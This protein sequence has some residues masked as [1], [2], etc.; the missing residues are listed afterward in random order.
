M[1]KGSPTRQRGDA[2]KKK[3]EKQ[4]Q[5][6]ILKESS[7]LAESDVKKRMQLVRALEGS[8]KSFFTKVSVEMSEIDR[9]DDVLELTQRGYLMLGNGLEAFALED[10]KAPNGQ[11]ELAQCSSQSSSSASSGSSSDE[12][13]SSCSLSRSGSSEGT[14]SSSDEEDHSDFHG[15]N[16]STSCR[17]SS[18]SGSESDSSTSSRGSNQLPPKKR[19]NAARRPC[20]QLKKARKEMSRSPSLHT[21]SEEEEESDNDGGKERQKD[22]KRKKQRKR[23]Q[24]LTPPSLQ[25]QGSSSPET[26]GPNKRKKAKDFFLARHKRLDFEDD[27]CEDDGGDNGP[28]SQAVA[29][30]S[31]AEEVDHVSDSCPEDDE[32]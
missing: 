7:S 22:E 5:L 9:N 8:I 14:G 32:D 2:Q 10:N 18:T 4:T 3:P 16:A 15:D 6:F 23:R 13:S 21:T 31:K 24:P 29:E 27:S 26:R 12:G 19:L 1:G 17:S 20:A 30:S 28:S 11:H 25:K